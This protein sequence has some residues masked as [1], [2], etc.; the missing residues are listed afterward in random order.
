MWSRGTD[1]DTSPGRGDASGDGASDGGG[2]GAFRSLSIP[3]YRRYFIS[4]TVSTLGTWM[5]SVGLSWLVYSLTGSGSALGVAITLQFIPMLVLG[6]IAGVWVERHDKRLILLWTQVAMMCEATLLGVLT[7]TGAVELWMVYVLAVFHGLMW[8]INGPANN[9]I[10]YEMVRPALL[11]NAVS[12]NLIMFNISRIIGPA[13]AGAAISVMGI[14]PCFLLNA[15]SFIPVIFV[16]FFIRPGDIVEMPRQPRAPGQLRAVFRY[17]LHERELLAGIVMLTCF[18]AFT[19][20][21]EVSIPIVAKETFGGGAALFGLL[22]AAI[23]VGAVV[24][25]LYAARRPHPTNRV[26][27]WNAVIAGAAML[28]AGLAPNLAVAFVML[29]IA[30]GGI[31]AWYG[32]IT[33]RY[34]LI[35]KPEYQGRSMA[36]WG[37]ALSGA[38]PVGA[39]LIGFI[40]QA[41]GGRATL[42]VGGAA[43]FVLCIPLWALIARRGAIATLRGLEPEDLP[44]HSPSIDTR[45]VFDAIDA[46]GG[47]DAAVPAGAGCGPTTEI[48]PKS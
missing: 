17:V 22:T 39:P 44:D 25:G 36:L 41:L 8:V 47:A 26:Q 7:V 10:V 11:T 3:I 42:I 34:Q 14:G 16:L 30:G 32:V 9:V 35:T 15:A 29:A 37:T 38:R 45:E 5:Q 28:G 48:T 27:L 33:A 6:P 31:T 40:G 18:G 46:T 23:G 2:H 4:Q 12:L 19:W 13:F 21:F 1:G 43:I 24:G 20:E